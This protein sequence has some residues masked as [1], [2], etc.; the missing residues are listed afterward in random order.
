[1]DVDEIRSAS[2]QPRTDVVYVGRLIDDKRVDLLHI[3]NTLTAAPAAIL[4][5]AAGTLRKGAPA[6]LVLIDPDEPFVVAPSELHSRARNT[7]FDGRRLQG[8]AQRTFV[9]GECV[10]NRAKETKH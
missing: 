7:P 6:D 1:M 3:L 9:A 10:F 5:L 2:P 4:G 8:R